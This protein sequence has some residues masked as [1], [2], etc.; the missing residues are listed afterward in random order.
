M[1]ITVR[2][3]IV[4]SLMLSGAVFAEN[5]IQNPGLEDLT[6]SFWNE[7]NGTFGVELGVGMDA[8]DVNV[9]YRS[10]KITKAAASAAA[11]GWLSDDNANKY[12]N[13]AASGTFTVRASIKTVG[14]NTSPTNDDAK[15]GVLFEFKTAAGAELATATLWADQSTASVDWAD[16]SDVV[17]LTEAPEQVYATLL[18]GKDATG[19]A[20]FDGIDCNTTEWSMGIFNGGAEDVAGW[21]DWYGGNGN[22]TYVTDADAHSGDYSVVMYQDEDL[23]TD[24]SELVYYSQPYA[25]EGGEWYKIGVWVKTEKVPDIGTGEFTLPSAE[26]I[27]GGINLCFFTHG[28]G[29]ETSWSDMG[30]RFVYINQLDSTTDWTHYEVAYQ[31]A[32]DAYGISVRARFN[33]WVTGTAYFDDFSV[34]KMGVVTSSVD[35]EDGEVANALP[36]SYKLAQN[37]PNPFNPE[38]AIE[39]SCPLTGY[40]RLDIYNMLGQKVR[41]LVNGVYSPGIHHVSWNARND[42]G[43]PVASGIYIYSLV[44]KDTQV[45]KKMLLIR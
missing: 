29:Y 42:F 9:G 1:K 30:D 12:W 15:I 35:D 36:T 44:T 6:P 45:T 17:I 31:A 10:F 5:L 23:G 27:D 28:Q 11:V 14:V 37:Y 8:A 38:T 2:A 13:N 24:Q 43:Q 16:L 32:D 40:V 7:L 41:T 33:N 21:M 19:T 3:L 22:Y 34:E 26:N 39:F 18:M 25:I 4:L 20:Y